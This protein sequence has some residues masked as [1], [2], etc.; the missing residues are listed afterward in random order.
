[1]PY[2]QLYYHLV[3]ATKNREPLITADLEPELHAYLRGKGLSLGGIVHAVG[4]VSDHT[5]VVVSI[6]PR[7]AVA[8]YVG[9][10]KGASSHWVN[11]LSGFTGPFAWQEGYGVIT[12]SKRSL[13]D[14][15]RYVLNQH[16]HHATGDLIS[17]MERIET[18]NVGP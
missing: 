17:A 18:E 11:H 5:H 8:G 9:Q 7:L 4:G 14:V 6:P 2:W 10:L 1:M 3:W 13:P 16:A 15:V 12:F